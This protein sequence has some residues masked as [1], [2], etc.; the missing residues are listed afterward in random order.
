MGQQSSR[1]HQLDALSV[2]RRNRLVR[3]PSQAEHPLK[4]ARTAVTGHPAAYAKVGCG[5]GRAGTE[6]GR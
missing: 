6:R 4:S 1:V 5:F 2:R 3:R